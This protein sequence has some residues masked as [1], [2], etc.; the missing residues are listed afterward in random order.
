MV[1]L[2]IV[3]DAH[4]AWSVRDGS[5]RG[6]LTS[7]TQTKDGYLWLGTGFGLLRFDGVRFLDC[8]P[9]TGESLPRMPI[10]K[11]TASRDGGHWIAGVQ[12]V[13]KLKAAADF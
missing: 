12:G 6:G 2:S 10:Y 9:P 4:T 13:E 8:E 7:V 11:L 5:L 3:N 1:S